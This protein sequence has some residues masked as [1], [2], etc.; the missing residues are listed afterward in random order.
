LNKIIKSQP[1]LTEK[2]KQARLAS[3][4]TVI[5]ILDDFLETT[6]S[7]FY[8]CLEKMLSN[9]RKRLTE[10]GKND[11]KEHLNVS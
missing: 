7:F 6:L 9:E 8:G 10:T 1:Q 2:D 4:R 3:E 5:L 11:F